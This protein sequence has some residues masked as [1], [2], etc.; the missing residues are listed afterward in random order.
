MTRFSRAVSLSLS[1]LSAFSMSLPGAF[2][3]APPHYFVQPGTCELV[4][5]NNSSVSLV[6]VNG[7]PGLKC[8]SNSPDS[9]F[10][11][12]AE[13]IYRS[14]DQFGNPTGFAIPQGVT[15]FDL[16]NNT[17][18]VQDVIQIIGYYDNGAVFLLDTGIENA[19]SGRY[20]VNTVQN[21]GS[22][23]AIGVRYTA[24]FNGSVIV[25]NFQI[26]GRPIGITGINH[27]IGCLQLPIT[28]SRAAGWN[29]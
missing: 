23:R 17:P 3:N 15:S 1:V 18:S 4:D 25:S 9:P 26:N 7:K 20:T 12:T 14:T 6:T 5:G 11:S 8:S 27:N 24:E 16:I 19:S 22:L 21:L 29:K 2:S 13:F 28:P 10:A